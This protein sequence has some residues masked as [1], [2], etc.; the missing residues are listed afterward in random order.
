MGDACR[1]YEAIGRKY[2]TASEGGGLGPFQLLVDNAGEMVANAEKVAL[3]VRRDGCRPR[4]VA[5]GGNEGQN[6]PAGVACNL[7]LHVDRDGGRERDGGGEKFGVGRN[8]Y[9]VFNDVGFNF[10]QGI[11]DGDDVG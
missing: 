8:V 5:G 6:K 10:W 7:I 11:F 1:D 9:G 3:H 2:E 4:R